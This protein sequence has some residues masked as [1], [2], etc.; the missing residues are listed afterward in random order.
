MSRQAS[1]D[2]STSSNSSRRDF[3]KT[4]GVVA[5]GGALVGVSTPKVHAGEDNTIRLALVGCGGR[6]GGAVG[7]ALSV[8]NES[9]QLHAMA[10]L[11]QDKIDR[12]HNARNGRYGDKVNVT[13]DRKSI[14]LVA[15][16]RANDALRHGHAAAR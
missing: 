1:R 7:N 8:P 16:R 11:Y 3:M 13:D 5:A 9:V 12:S 2:R 4:A 15:D 10:D 14:G 6:G